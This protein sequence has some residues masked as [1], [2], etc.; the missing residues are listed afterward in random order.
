MAPSWQTNNKYIFHNR[1]VK[2]NID[3]HPIITGACPTAG[4]VGCL[5]ALRTSNMLAFLRDGNKCTCCD[6]ETEGADQTFYLA[7]SQFSDTVPTSRSAD[8]IMA[9]VW[10]ENNSITCLSHWHDWAIENRDQFP[11]VFH[12][13]GGRLKSSAHAATF[14][15]CNIWSTTSCNPNRSARGT[16]C[17]FEP[18]PSQSHS[19]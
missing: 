17:N 4:F 1:E 15:V 8:S 5:L 11:R 9:G 16:R 6:T 13:R 3:P 7:Q 2:V 14:N 10:Q 18:V 19:K 12:S